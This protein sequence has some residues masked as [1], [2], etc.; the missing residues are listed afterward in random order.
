[1]WVYGVD[2]LSIT[3][4]VEMQLILVNGGINI[5]IIYVCVNI[6]NA[7]GEVQV[8]AA[9]VDSPIVSTTVIII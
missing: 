4:F 5:I 6:L 8:V 2:R 7:D 3:I 9:V 1:M